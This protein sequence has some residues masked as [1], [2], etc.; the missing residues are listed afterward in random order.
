M[1]MR[2]VHHI[3]AFK[4][5][6]PCAAA[7]AVWSAGRLVVAETR[8]EGNLIIPIPEDHSSLADSARRDRLSDASAISGHC[9]INTGSS[10]RS[11]LSFW[12]MSERWRNNTVV[13]I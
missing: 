4:A 12:G 10:R 11:E 1:V 9:G 8:W 13:F 5:G 6:T 2:V 3:T 7:S